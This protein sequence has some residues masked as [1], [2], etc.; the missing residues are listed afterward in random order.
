MPAGTYAVR[1]HS[2]SYGFAVAA[3]ATV[4]VNWNADRTNAAGSSVSSSFVGGKSMTI[5]GAGFVTN[6]PSNN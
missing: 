1:V 3:P 2:D 6:N 4:T 5:N